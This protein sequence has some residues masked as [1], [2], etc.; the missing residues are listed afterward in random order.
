MNKT[1]YV[2]D[3]D[4]P[5]WEKAQGL[6]DGKLS[7]LVTNY[8]KRYVATQEAATKGYERIVL[9][10]HENEIPKA[11]AFQGRWIIPLNEPFVVPEYN[12]PPNCYAVAETPKKNFVFLTFMD[13]AEENSKSDTDRYIY[14]GGFNV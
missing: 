2:R 13:D 12:G 5:V 7:S 8:L 6:A 10:L 4:A 3:E 14:W 1:L 9:R 11:Y